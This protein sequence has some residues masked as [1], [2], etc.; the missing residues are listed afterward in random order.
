MKTIEEMAQEIMLSLVGNYKSDELHSAERD[1]VVY[2]SIEL[3]KDLDKALKD[4]FDQGTP[5]AILDAT[6]GKGDE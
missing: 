4:Q 2:V 1:E 5:Q 6:K 3:A